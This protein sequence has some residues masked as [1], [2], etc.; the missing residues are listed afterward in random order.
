[1][2]SKDT[3]IRF[4][5]DEGKSLRQIAKHVSLSH[6][7][8]KKRLDRIPDQNT[9]TIEANTYGFEYKHPMEKGSINTIISRLDLVLEDL[10]LN[11]T[12]KKVIIDAGCWRFEKVSQ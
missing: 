6:V 4:L 10:N 7:G 12:N 3:Q 1:M 2:D 5:K 11:E 9:I 8:V